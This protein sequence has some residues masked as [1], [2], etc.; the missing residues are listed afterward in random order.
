MVVSTLS[1]FGGRA[2]RRL[3]RRNYMYACMYGKEER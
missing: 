1:G 3:F 2:V